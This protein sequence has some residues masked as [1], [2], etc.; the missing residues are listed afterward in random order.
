MSWFHYFWVHWVRF[1]LCG[2]S[3]PLDLGEQ[4][5][6]SFFPSVRYSAERQVPEVGMGS[7]RK[8]IFLKLVSEPGEG[9]WGLRKIHPNI[10]QVDKQMSHFLGTWSL[11]FSTSTK[12]TLKIDCAI[13]FKNSQT[14]WHMMAFPQ[15]D[16]KLPGVSLSAG[17]QDNVGRKEQPRKGNRDSS[18][19]T[20]SSL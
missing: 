7:P 6:Q 11:M 14:W 18:P 9:R 4:E 20:S 12:F 2:F 8:V 13:I 16:I 15:G 3:M 17:W 1:A 10:W 19:C 5:H